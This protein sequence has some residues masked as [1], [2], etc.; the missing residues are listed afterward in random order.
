MTKTAKAAIIAAVAAS[1]ALAGCGTRDESNS[2]GGD[3]VEKKVVTIGTISPLTGDLSAVGSGIRNGVDLAV[4]QANASDAI[5]GWEIKIEPMDDEAKPDTGKNAATKLAADDTVIAVVGTMNSSVAQ[6][7]A[8]VL[9]A[10]DI[11]MVSPANT[12]PA[13]TK[14]ADLNAPVRQNKSFFRLCASDD[15]QGPFAADYLLEQGIKK[16]ATIHDKKVY[17]QGLVEE[18]TKAFTAGGG[19]IVAAET[20]NPED[21]DY[22]TVISKVKSASP[23]AIY[24]GGEYPQAGPL[25]QQAKAAG[26][27]IPL[28]GGD[29]LYDAAYI[30][31]AGKDA[32]EGDLTTSVGAPVDSLESAKAFAEAYAAGG[33]AEGIGPY[34]AYSYDA[35]NVIISALKT[36]LASATDAKSARAATVD[37]IQ[38]FTTTTAATGDI[39]FDEFGDN[40]N[41]VMTVYKVEGGEWKAAYT[42]TAM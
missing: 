24:Y 34:G 26:L 32:A 16:V 11:S 15:K 41:Q 9:N 31:L 17:G 33:Y 6:P 27:K 28:M 8:P 37:A 14:G 35:A 2:A 7:V 4:K 10:A 19:E 21:K 22:N 13:L 40:T 38:S 25:S 5:P 36:T 20:I 42:G 23:E 39:S 18:F 29:G 30:E 1:V 3:T 12:S